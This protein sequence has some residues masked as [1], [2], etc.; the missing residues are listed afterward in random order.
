MT[1]TI[2]P[3]ACLVQY[4]KKGDLDNKPA[5][6]RAIENLLG[7]KLNIKE[8]HFVLI[9]S[10]PLFPLDVNE[11][12]ACTDCKFKLCGAMVL[13]TKTVG[14]V[15]SLTIQHQKINTPS[16][17]GKMLAQAQAI[18]RGIGVHLVAIH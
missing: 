7:K 17:H 8:S 6:S 4:W 9:A 16:V 15:S 14:G 11:F 3:D 12:S 2:D 5:V 13:E 10:V 18:A 1:D